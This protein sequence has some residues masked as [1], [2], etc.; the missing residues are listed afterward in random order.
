[1][2]GKHILIFSFFI[3]AIV[4]MAGIPKKSQLYEINADGDPDLIAGRNVNMVS[5]ITLPDGD[6]YL[7]RQNEPSIAVST[8][9]PLHLLAG[10]N[11]YRTVDMPFS[12]GELPGQIQNQATGDA[13]LGVFKSL[14]GGESWKS[15]L[16]DGYPQLLTSKSPLFGYQ[17]AADPVVRAGSNGLFF[18]SGIVFNRTNPTNHFLRY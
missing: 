12:E 16:L 7:Q 18:Y 4:A 5:G 3:I 10:A 2:R 17:A 11:D 6:P 9:N 8:R 15:T 1:M 13:W 14:D